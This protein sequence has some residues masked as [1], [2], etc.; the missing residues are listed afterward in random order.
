MRTVLVI[1]AVAVASCFLVSCGPKEPD[2]A[3]LQKTVDEYNAASKEAMMTGNSDKVLAFFEDD[4]MEM[5]PNQPTVKGKEAIK[6]F[7]AQ[8][9][10]SG[11]KMTAVE[12][13]PV[14]I[15]AGGTIA[16]EIGTY[17]MTIAV[18]KMGDVKDKGKYI[19]LW[20]QQADGSWKVRAE[21]WNTDMPM[22]SMEKST[23]KADTKHKMTTQKGSTKKSAV[24]KKSDTKKKATAKK[25]PAKKKTTTKKSNTK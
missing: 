25:A 14:E 1:V 24:S 6:A 22:P 4:G 9:M 21:T 19:A 11:V 10:K 7:Q 12:F 5:A 13:A 18:P 17:D 15:Q 20:R 3:A 8:M 2:K 23:K 16:Y